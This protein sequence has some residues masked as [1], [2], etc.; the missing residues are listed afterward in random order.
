MKALMALGLLLAATAV[1]QADAE[2]KDVEARRSVSGRGHESGGPPHGGLEVTPLGFGRGRLRLTLSRDASIPISETGA[3]TLNGETFRSQWLRRELAAR[4]P[5][6]DVQFVEVVRSVTRDDVPGATRELAALITGDLVELEEVR[7]L[8]RALERLE[9]TRIAVDISIYAAEREDDSSA[10][11]GVAVRFLPAEALEERRVAYESRESWTRLARLRMTLAN[12]EQ[13]TARD[14]EEFAYIK[15]WDVEDVGGRAVAVPSIGTAAE[16]VQVRIGALLGPDGSTLHGDIEVGV[17]TILEH[18]FPTEEFEIPRIGRR[19]VELPRVATISWRDDDLKLT[20]DA[21][22]LVLTG[23][24]RPDQR[25]EGGRSRAMTVL[26]ALRVLGPPVR[27]QAGAVLGFDRRQ[28]IA[29]VRAPVDSE[30]QPGQRLT[31]ARAGKLVAEGRVVEVVGR[32][33]T[34]TLQSGEVK[35]GDIAR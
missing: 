5:E 15:D 25:G 33:L 1:G 2:S 10:G 11:P 23:L 21:A 3:V 6:L 27:T 29:F 7:E 18:P 32:V 20:G 30:A 16:G 35:P 9:K 14:V 8:V 19:V 31:F 4:H 12:G 28:R 13:M 26:C 34:V 22:G 17:G 24:R